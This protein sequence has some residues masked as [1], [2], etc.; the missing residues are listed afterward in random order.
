M[1]QNNKKSS[2]ETYDKI[3]KPT[4]SL[5]FD[6]CGELLLYS[7]D[8]YKHTK[9]FSK[10]PY[11]LYESFIPFFIINWYLNPLEIPYYWSMSQLLMAAACMVPKYWQF[12]ALQFSIKKIWLMRG[13]K[14]VKIERCNAS[15]DNYIDWAEVR[16]IKP[17]SKDFKEF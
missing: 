6:R 8:P 9:M 10:Y 1:E 7:C 15:G 13:G 14:V 16:F 5:E 17:I 4:H 12:D 2:I 11:I 3:F